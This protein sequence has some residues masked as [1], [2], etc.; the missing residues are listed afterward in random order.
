MSSKIKKLI[1]QSYK[2]HFD[3]FLNFDVIFVYTIY[4][5]LFIQKI[6]LFI[7]NLICFVNVEDVF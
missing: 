3:D 6:L 4:R 2:G 1:T 5:K 7:L